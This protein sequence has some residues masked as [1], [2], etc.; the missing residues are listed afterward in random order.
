MND[1]TMNG[2]GWL[3]AVV[4][5]LLVGN[6][7]L[8]GLFGGGNGAAAAVAAGYATQQD[9]QNAINAQSTQNGL[10]SIMLSSANNNYETARLIDN[11]TMYLSNQNNTNQLAAIN[12][13]NTVNQNMAQGFNTLAQSIAAMNH[14]LE[15]CCCSIKTQMLQDKYDALQN[16]Y[17][18]A[19]NDLSNA[20]QTQTILNAMGRWVGYPPSA[21][22]AANG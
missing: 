21:A 7:G 4:I 18:S 13:F 15:N 22:A 19:Q 6:N 2:G 9:V 16:Q 8:G 17:L 20:A 5:L 14:N 12:G 3:W 10:Q 11:Q 1:N